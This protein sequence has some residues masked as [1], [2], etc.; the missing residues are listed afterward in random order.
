MESLRL[1]LETSSINGLSH[2]SHSKGSSKIFWIFTVTLGFI[3]AGVLINQ[4]FTNWAESPIRT[5]IETRPISEL[6]F[7]KVTVCPPTN[8][9]TI[10]NF[11]L[12][13]L[14]N[15]T[16]LLEEI[17]ENMIQFSFLQLQESFYQ[18]MLKNISKVQE[19]NMFFNWYLGFTEIRFP[20][21]MND[22]Y[23]FEYLVATSASNGSLK[24]Y[25][26]GQ[27][28]HPKEIE[29]IFYYYTTIYLP[30]V[31]KGNGNFTLSLEVERI[32]LDLSV[33]KISADSDDEFATANFG[34]ASNKKGK[35]KF[36]II[37]HNESRKTVNFEFETDQKYLFKNISCSKLSYFNVIAERKVTDDDVAKNEK[38]GTIPGFNLRWNLNKLAE[39]TQ[40]FKDDDKCK[41][42][43]R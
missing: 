2:I 9:F 8:E 28:F 14:E 35:D 6:Q 16:L 1:Y 7:P 3:I 42:F 17:K 19:E 30:D 33:L 29:K 34:M 24:S 36:T 25:G 5:I 22:Y 21:Y 39:S 18:G 43:R 40:K 11:D 37:G 32:A 26:F 4:A 38:L 15:E 31:A 27:P 12:K 13:A 20:F 23:G 10:L 41:E